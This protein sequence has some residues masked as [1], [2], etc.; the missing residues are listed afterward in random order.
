MDA[1]GSNFNKGRIYNAAFKYVIK[2]LPSVD[3]VVLHDVDLVPVAN[4]SLMGEAADYRCRLMPWHLTRKVRLLETNTEREYNQF[5]TGGI[6]SLRV[7]HFADVNGFSNK[8]FGWGAEGIFNQKQT[9][10]SE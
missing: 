9:F 3:C 8:Y 1:S 2:N 5:L 4:A 6:L 10:E 7:G